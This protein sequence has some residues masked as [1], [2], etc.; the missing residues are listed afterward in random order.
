[1]FRTTRPK[2]QLLVWLVVATSGP[3][4]T[5]AQAT[6]ADLDTALTSVRSESSKG[7]WKRAQA[8]LL[9]AIEEHTGADYVPARW[10]EIE[11]ALAR[12]V[13]YSDYER[14][15]PRDV[16]HGQLVSWNES[17]GAIKLRYESGD[18]GLAA[19]G[20]DTA[21]G[22]GDFLTAQLGYYLHPLLFKGPYHI[23]IRGKQLTQRW[24]LP[25][26]LVAWHWGS[27][28]GEAYG[29]A[30]AVAF[31]EITGIYERRDGDFQ[32]LGSEILS[33]D[34]DRPYEF[35]VSVASSSIS[36]YYN[37]KRIVKSRRP[38]GE[39]GQ[40]GFTGFV[41]VEEVVITGEV[42]PAWLA[43]LIDERVHNDWNA[44]RAVF[45][46]FEYLPA[47]VADAVEGEAKSAKEF[48][49]IAPGEEDERN[50][51]IFEKACRYIANGELAEGLNYALWLGEKEA[52]LP[53]REWLKAYFLAY[54]GKLPE[55]IEHLN[56]LSELDPTFFEGRLLRMQLLHHVGTP[57]E[58]ED[59]FIRLLEDFPDHVQTYEALARIH[60]S[61]GNV[62]EAGEALTMA[63]EQGLPARALEGL[64]RNLLRAKH[65]A[66]WP[67]RYTFESKN[68]VVS[69]D[70]SQGICFEISQELEKYYRK[71]AAH[72]RRPKNVE[73][74]RFQVYFFSGETGYQ[75]YCEDLLGS[76]AEST[77][78]LYSPSLKQLLIWNSP[79]KRTMMRTVRHE[80]FHQYLDRITS[81]APVWLNEGMAE[82]FE[83]SR[84]IQTRWKDDQVNE[85]HVALLRST[86]GKW[87][88]LEDFVYLDDRSFRANSGLHYPQAWA[89]VHYLYNASSRSKKRLDS[90]LDALHEGA[91]RKQALESAFEE[92]DWEK[93][94]L[95]FERYVHALK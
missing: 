24:A 21:R 36:A 34:Y 56:R 35:K 58:R 6:A 66:T 19:A 72:I 10:V 48:G 8:Q 1:M 89:F 13:F 12:C 18:G 25:T 62:D 16:V 85:Q 49:D 76:P 38:K 70:L 51:A 81:E 45:D 44:F 55:A 59:E 4:D 90:L 95:E 92:V 5:A 52:P 64:S 77:L 88:P 29:S 30:Y 67:K 27:L 47:W 84:L 80:G 63:L 28:Q 69:S 3:T 68:Y 15:D 79:D 46:P 14:P 65:G 26:F 60:L 39:F 54:A 93:L 73:Q 61:D 83:Q 33:I 22:D 40:F 86:S 11:E 17:S 87:T 94:E 50:R 41:G 9:E 23:T 53:A 42:E 74:R 75:S 7:R 71:Y 20:A 82:Y 37:G 2:L 31:G 32:L 43:G 57:G 91:N 78:G